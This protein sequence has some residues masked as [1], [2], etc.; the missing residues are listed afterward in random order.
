ML[1]DGRRRR[2]VRIIACSFDNGQRNG[3]IERADVFLTGQQKST[4]SHQAANEVARIG[5][6]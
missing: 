6:F 5:R 1:K 4:S 2:K 3:L